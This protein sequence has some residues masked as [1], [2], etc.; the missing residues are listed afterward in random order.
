[1]CLVRYPSQSR[2]GS[3]GKWPSSKP[4]NTT[5][6]FCCRGRATQ[7]LAHL[8]A[9]IA[10]CRVT[11]IQPGCFHNNT[12]YTKVHSAGGCIFCVIFDIPRVQVSTRPRGDTYVLRLRLASS[13]SV[14]NWLQFRSG[15]ASSRQL[16][17]VTLDPGHLEPCTSQHSSVPLPGARPSGSHGLQRARG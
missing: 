5:R 16:E 2:H 10:L 1:M 9:L 15:K 3:F 13:G 11:L 6:R 12:L 8:D 7:M 14:N 4:R 17:E